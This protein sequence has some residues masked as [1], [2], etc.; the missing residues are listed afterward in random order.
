MKTTINLN[1]FIQGFKDTDRNYYTYEGYKALFNYFELFE[2]DCDIQIEF[3]VIAICC[4]YTEYENLAEIIET[5]P[6]VIENL[7]DL[8]NH[9][10][11]I[12][13]DNGIIIQDF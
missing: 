12:E 6:N 8:Y 1:D 9:T 5:Y 13:F 2:D 4:E 3:D 11:V 10:Q 7:D